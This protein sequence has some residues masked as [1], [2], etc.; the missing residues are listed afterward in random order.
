MKFEFNKGLIEG[1][2]ILASWLVV[3]LITAFTPLALASGLLLPNAFEVLTARR[4]L[5]VSALSGI[6]LSDAGHVL[7]LFG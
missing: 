5:R 4:G 2:L 6:S 1:A 7:P 3:A